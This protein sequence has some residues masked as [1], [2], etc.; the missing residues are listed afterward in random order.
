MSLTF[1]TEPL[2]TPHPAP[3]PALWC[4]PFQWLLPHPSSCESENREPG[5]L[6][7]PFPKSRLLPS[8]AGFTSST[9][10]VC[11]LPSPPFLLVFCRGFSTSLLASVCRFPVHG[12]HRGSTLISECTSGA[13]T[14][15]SSV[16]LVVE[17]SETLDIVSQQCILSLDG[18]YQWTVCFRAEPRPA[19]AEPLFVASHPEPPSLSGL[20][21]HAVPVMERGIGNPPCGDDKHLQY[22][23]ELVEAQRAIE[24]PAPSNWLNREC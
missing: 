12:L 15:D 19:S 3:R 23:K 24:A 18:S 11:L 1:R 7:V 4:S 14:R 20:G 17:D 22:A 6:F 10:Q 5:P 16:R 13:G 2:S 9:P 21:R 8:P